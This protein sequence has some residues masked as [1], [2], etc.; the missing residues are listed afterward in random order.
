MYVWSLSQA[1]N[2]MSSVEG[3]DPLVN[4]TILHLRA[5]NIRSLNKLSSNLVNLQYLNC[6]SVLV[7]LLY[8]VLAFNLHSLSTSTLK[9]SAVNF[10]R[11]MPCIA[12]TMLSQDVCL[13]LS[14]CLRVCPSHGGI[15]SK[16]LNML[17]N[18]F[19]PSGSHTIQENGLTYRHSFFQ[20]TVA[21]SF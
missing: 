15:A 19:S 4:L 18:F 14:I 3:L 5:N 6:R 10:Y 8:Y 13:L 2:E 16:R 9:V 7:S 1:N 11:A 17:T 12:R 21:Q 20:D